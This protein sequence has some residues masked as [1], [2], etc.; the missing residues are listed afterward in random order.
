MATADE[1]AQWI[2]SNADKKG[3]PEFDVVAQAYA[4]AR[5]EP[6]V[7]KAGSALNDIGR[8]VGLTARYGMEGLA[9]TAQIG[10]EPIRF[11]TDRLSGNTGN[12]KPLGSLASDAADWMGLP[13]PQGATER[14][15]GDA[16]RLLAGSAATLGAGQIAQK[17]AGAIKALGN[18]FT[19]APTVQ[20]TSAAGAGLAGGSSRE[21][22]GSPLQQVTS[23][24]IGGLGGAG[25]V[26]LGNFLAQKATGLKN[27][28]MLSNT[29]IDVKIG[30]VLKQAGVD[31]SKVPE[32]VRQ[33]MRAELKAALNTDQDL[34]PA[35]VGRLLDFKSNNLTPTRGMLSLDPVQIT[36]EQNLAK[37][38]SNGSDGQMHVLPRIQNQNNSQLIANM[39]QMGGE[40]G[41]MMG[42]GNK[43]IGAIQAKDATLQ[44]GVKGA[45]DSARAMPGGNVPL[46]RTKVINGIYDALAKENK[47][48][49]LPENVSAMLDTISKGT[50]RAGGQDHHV[51]FDAN[52]LDN[53]MTTIATAQRGTADGNIKAALAIARKAIDGAA[54]SPVKN[55]FGGNQLVTAQGANT[56]RNADASAGNFMDALNTARKTAAQRFGWQE[57]GRPIEAAL[58]GAQPDNFIKQF[59]IDGTLK[60]AQDLAANAPT[61]PIKE[62]IVNYLKNKALNSA[63]DELGKFSQS[64][65]NKELKALAES[66]KLKL[67]FSPEEISQLQSMGRAAGYMQAQPVGSAV[68]NSNSGA[69]LLGKGMDWLKNI[70]VAGPMVSPSLEYIA[71]NFRQKQ[72]TNLTKGLLADTQGQPLLGSVLAPGFALGGLLAPQMGN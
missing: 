64:T 16:T 5:Q 41:S 52:A 37:I 25:A 12:T 63:S 17:G 24:V 19:Q 8:Q 49:F 65:F 72:A 3:T 48:A 26:W 60:D 13:K 4:E 36:R 58:G 40:R 59:V 57:S 27:S 47:L 53:L 43:S 20:L 38:A 61:A 71:I 30:S 22:G 31:Y 62:A 69:L 70:P 56:L 6:A 2:V 54:L 67:F 9:N 7:A 44:A 34:D 11:F 21:A 35:A 1:Y 33:G 66:G 51:P 42:A 14:V 68:N 10:T 45:Y 18:M 29:D 28:L 15:V 46:D 32:R 39:N 23:S 55:T 50:I